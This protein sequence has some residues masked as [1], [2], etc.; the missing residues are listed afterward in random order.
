MRTKL[1]TLGIVVVLSA[2]VFA[3][4]VPPADDPERGEWAFRDHC[5]TCHG[6]DG[7]GGG[8]MAEIMSL[9]MPDLT[10]LASENDGEFPLLRVLQRI[11]GRDPILAHGGD[12]PVF[13][14]GFDSDPV[15]IT[16]PGGQPVIT[17]Q[18][19]ADLTAWLQ[20]IQK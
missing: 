10:A 16:G 4:Q 5:A 17:G 8:P 14:H 11:D 6:R 18:T 12:M 19:I 1:V 15:A 2:P 9:P 7:R 3:D 20:S 13:G